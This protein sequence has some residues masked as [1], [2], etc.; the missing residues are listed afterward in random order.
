MATAAQAYRAT[1]FR[2]GLIG[3]KGRRGKPYDN[4]EA[5]SFWKTLKLEAVDPMAYETFAEV[6]KDLP[7]FIDEV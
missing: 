5:E 1:L 6:G 2:R 7:R 4:A 3:S